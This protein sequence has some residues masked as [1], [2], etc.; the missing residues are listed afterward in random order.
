[1]LGEQADKK[2]VGGLLVFEV[3]QGVF[4]G[5]TALVPIKKGQPNLEYVERQRQRLFLSG[6]KQ[7]GGK[8]TKTGSTTTRFV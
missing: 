7:C 6:R 3:E 4:K 1:M 2:R 8:G 5:V